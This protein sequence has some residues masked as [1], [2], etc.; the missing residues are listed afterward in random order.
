MFKIKFS[1]VNNVIYDLK[2]SK[3][4]LKT[5]KKPQTLSSGFFF[6]FYRGVF[7]AG[8]CEANPG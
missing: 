8:F 4:V 1:Y 5:K 2:I 3:K 6:G 7:W